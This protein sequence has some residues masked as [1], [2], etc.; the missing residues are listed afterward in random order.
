MGTAEVF[1]YSR[2][3]SVVGDS[4]PYCMDDIGEATVGGKGGKNGS[5]TIMRVSA[6]R[7]R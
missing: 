5:V 4:F 3:A 6:G 1:S 7:I 2:G